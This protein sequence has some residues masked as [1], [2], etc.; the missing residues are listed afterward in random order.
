M[1]DVP[2]TTKHYRVPPWLGVPI[3]VVGYG[4][5]DVAAPIVVASFAHRWGWH[6]LRPGVANLIGVPLIVAG[7]AVILLAGRVHRAAQRRRDGL[8]VTFDRQ[9]LMT[10]N[11]L[12]TDGVYRHTRNPLYVADFAMW[13]GWAI[14]LGSV[15]VAIGLGILVTGLRLGVRV[16]ERGLRHQ[17]GDEWRRYAAATPRF[18]RLRRAR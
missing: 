5:V 4:F 16:E 15:P 14:F 3:A 8:V 11:Y 13:A 17:F 10:P 9:H 18:F 6:G 12:V 2:A 1:M 7:V